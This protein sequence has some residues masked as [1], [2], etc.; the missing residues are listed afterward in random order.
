MGMRNYRISVTHHNYSVQL[1]SES[2]RLGELREQPRHAHATRGSH[3]HVLR[4]WD[5][6][7]RRFRAARLVGPNSC[8]QPPHAYAY[9]LD[10]H[11]GSCVAVFTHHSASFLPLSARA[12]FHSKSLAAASACLLASALPPLALPPLL[13][14]SNW[15]PTTLSTKMRA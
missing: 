2:S 6:P 7:M 15:L 9:A 10:T 3:M 8:A 1:H 11:T 5:H 12:F 13:P 14:S 4:G